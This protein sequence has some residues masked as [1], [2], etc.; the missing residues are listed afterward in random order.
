M[1]IDYKKS[2]EV[3]VLTLPKGKIHPTGDN[4]EIYLDAHEVKD[5]ALAENW[6]RE[7]ENIKRIIEKNERDWNIS[8]AEYERNSDHAKDNM[9]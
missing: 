7:E 4:V 2:S 1:K 5:I 6:T 3:Y 9:A 8:N